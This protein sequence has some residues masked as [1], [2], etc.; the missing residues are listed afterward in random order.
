MAFW[1][2]G[3]SKRTARLA[4]DLSRL[5]LIR[6]LLGGLLISPPFVFSEVGLLRNVE[7]L[8]SAMS[9]DIALH[10]CKH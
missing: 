5:L 4:G 9:Q 2:H 8:C 6:P 10:N 7:E 3:Q 1:P